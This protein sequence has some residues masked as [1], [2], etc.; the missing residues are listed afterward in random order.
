M[1]RLS[2]YGEIKDVNQLGILVNLPKLGGEIFGV[3]GFAGRMARAYASLSI[4]CFFAN[5]TYQSR[6]PGLAMASLFNTF[7]NG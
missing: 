7:S 4:K 1:L 5:A 2:V 6:Q 3:A